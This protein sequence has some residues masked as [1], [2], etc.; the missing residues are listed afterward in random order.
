MS[1]VIY[2]LPHYAVLVRSLLAGVVT[3][4]QDAE[5]ELALILPPVGIHHRVEEEELDQADVKVAF[6]VYRQIGRTVDAAV[7]RLTVIPVEHA[8][9]EFF[10]VVALLKHRLAAGYVQRILFRNPADF[11]QVKLL[12]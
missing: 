12:R 1:A 5:I 11:G 4:D 3:G 9:R 2:H 8:L 7:S 6:E 10:G